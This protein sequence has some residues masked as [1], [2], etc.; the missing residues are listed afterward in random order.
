[1]HS[2]FFRDF[3]EIV[4]SFKANGTV[5]LKK[6]LIW[7]S[8]RCVFACTI[9]DAWLVCAQ[10]L[11]SNPIF[12]ITT[13]RNVGDPTSKWRTSSVHNSHLADWSDLERMSM[14]VEIN[15]DTNPPVYSVY[16][17]NPSESNVVRLDVTKRDGNMTV[18]EPKSF[19]AQRVTE[20]FVECEAFNQNTNFLH[21]PFVRIGPSLVPQKRKIHTFSETATQTNE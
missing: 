15:T 1:M 11:Q 4:T 20:T 13:P 3:P 12:R 16:I 2:F 5:F 18:D 21:G 14:H 9:D 6:Q 7:G 19:P 8:E 17:Y 10:R